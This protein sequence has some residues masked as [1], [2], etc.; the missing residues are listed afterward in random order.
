MDREG[1]GQTG[2]LVS[3]PCH[4][5]RATVR[6]DI[7]GCTDCTVDC[8]MAVIQL[9][10]CTALLQTG[11]N[12]HPCH[13]WVFSDFT[14]ST[15]LTHYSGKTNTQKSKQKSEEESIQMV[16]MERKRVMILFE[17][18]FFSEWKGNKKWSFIVNFIVNNNPYIQ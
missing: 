18:D 8:T 14:L 17:E 7:R 6:P 11:Y 15:P 16:G 5:P 10:K 1:T 3:L 12:V 4:N 9:Q 2:R 13:T